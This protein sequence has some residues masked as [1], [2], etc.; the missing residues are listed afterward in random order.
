MVTYWTLNHHKFKSTL[1]RKRSINTNTKKIERERK[2]KG[3]G[4]KEK[5]SGIEISGTE[6]MRDKKD[7]GQVSYNVYI[8]DL[9]HSI[10]YK[11][12]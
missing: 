12:V 8:Y 11:F 4:W 1:R 6:N 9:G 3:G 2:W 7:P 5:E 10:S